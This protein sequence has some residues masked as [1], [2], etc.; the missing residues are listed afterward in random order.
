MNPSASHGIR[1]SGV[2]KVF[3]GLP[4]PAVDDVSLDIAPGEFM[5]FLGPSGSGKTTT[6][7]MIAGF[8]PLTSGSI[9]VDGKDI[10]GLKPHKRDLGVVFQQYALFPHLTVAKNVAF[11]LQQRA[12]PKSEVQSRAADALTLVG[13]SDC[14][15][16]LPRQL[17]GGQQ[18]RVA[19][20]RAVVYQPRALLMDEPLGALDKKLR[21]QLRKEIARMHRELGMTF[22]F[23]THDQEEAL[24]LSD[25]IA[26][27]NNGKVEQVGTPTELYERP[28]TLFVAQFL[29]ESNVFTEDG[30]HGAIVVRPERLDLHAGPDSVPS[31]HQR[32]K[33]V[34]T[35]VVYVGNHH[36]IG[37]RFDDGAEGSAMRLAGAALPA[38]PG[39]TVIA[40]W[41][42]S[43]QT[44]VQGG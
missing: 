33:A 37:L 23:V 39:E 38:A 8:V 5:T 3:A 32:R 36:R 31:G 25:R 24:T 13:L 14:A 40:S 6:L 26:V 44:S 27:F 2:S 7:S 20:A 35:E 17:S 10:S 1:I 42:Q 21:D 4:R 22:L 28:A 34:I 15:D 30:D 11:P 9:C 43:H 18:Q 12:V 29:G 19:L 41:S 16:R